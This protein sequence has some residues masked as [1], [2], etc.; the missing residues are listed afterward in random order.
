MTPLLLICAST[1]AIAEP[2]PAAWTGDDELVMTLQPYDFDVAA[3]VALLRCPRTYPAMP[4]AQPAS[5]LSGSP[6][7]LRASH[8][9]GSSRGPGRCHPGNRAMSIE[10]AR[11]P[12]L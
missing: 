3:W 12:L 10:Q 9:P 11:P 7:T 6:K 1:L 4:P 5:R 8:R 2:A